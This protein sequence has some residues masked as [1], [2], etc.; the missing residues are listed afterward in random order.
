M[1][2]FGSENYVSETELL[3][4]N[5]VNPG[6]PRRAQEKEIMGYAIVTFSVNKE[7]KVFNLKDKNVKSFCT[8]DNPYDQDARFKECSTFKNNA[9]RAARKL[10]YFP[11]FINDEP[12]DVH[13]VEHKFTYLIE[14]EITKDYLDNLRLAAR[15]DEEELKIKQKEIILA[16]LIRRCEGF[17]WSNDV[18]IASCVQQEAYR[19]LQLEKQNYQI[20]MLEQKLA[21]AQM[22][23]DEPLFLSL[24]NMYADSMKQENIN[25]IKKDIAI[26]KTKSAY[27]YDNAEAALKSLYRTNN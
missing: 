10:K 26:L 16:G 12:I 15:E 19:D 24:L 21:S 27:S 11:K 14:N 22:V 25:Q 8:K 17:G 7:G 2:S 13:N 4:Q 3:R 20:R 6:Y 9:I 23:N 5:N 18:D 1:F